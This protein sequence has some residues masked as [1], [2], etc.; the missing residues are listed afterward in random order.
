MNKQ[1]SRLPHLKHF[2]IGTTY[3]HVPILSLQKS[4][5]YLY[6]YKHLTLSTYYTVSSNTFDSYSTILSPRLT[7]VVICQLKAIV[8]F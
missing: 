6:L 7:D 8:K 4:L 3:I 1:T 2:S 5:M